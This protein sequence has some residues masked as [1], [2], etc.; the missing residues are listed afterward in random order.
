MTVLRPGPIAVALAAIVTSA[1]GVVG[2]IGLVAPILARL[3]GARKTLAVLVWSSLIGATLLLLTD[4]AVQLLA[5]Q[6]S[7]FL[8]T[9]AVTAVFGS[10][11]MLILLGRL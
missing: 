5:G 6:F 8:P 9:G 11:L 7:D 1:V 2:F 3:A 10:P 4:T